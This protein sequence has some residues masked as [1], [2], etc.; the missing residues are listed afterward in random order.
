MSDKDRVLQEI[1]ENR[2]GAYWHK[3]LQI[4]ELK[5]T[6][7]G[8]ALRIK[9]ILDREN[10]LGDIENQLNVLEQLSDEFL[11]V[12]EWYKEVLKKYGLFDKRLNI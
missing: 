1:Y 12:P 11:I 9:S 10:E 6:S 8:S 2:L 5:E 3:L 7:T 4:K